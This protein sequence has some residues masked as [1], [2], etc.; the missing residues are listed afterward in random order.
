MPKL[1]GLLHPQPQIG[2]VAA[3]LADPKRHGRRDRSIF[4]KDAVEQR[5][6]Y[7]EIPGNLRYRPPQRRQNILAKKL[8]GVG[9]GSDRASF[10]S[11]TL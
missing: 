9:D 1:I 3:E 7:P 11:R 10:S 5:P 4:G 2:T 8:P 6:C